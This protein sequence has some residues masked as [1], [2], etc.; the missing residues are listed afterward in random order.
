MQQHEEN[1]GVQLEYIAQFSPEWIPP[2][3][4][5]LSCPVFLQT[6]APHL[7]LPQKKR[8]MRSSSQ[9]R[10][11]KKYDA[12]KGRKYTHLGQRR[13]TM[14]HEYITFGRERIRTNV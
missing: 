7:N 9:D 1:G 13:S 10:G 3:N 14:Q 4:R 2:W 8:R 12:A 11:F 5:T 6:K